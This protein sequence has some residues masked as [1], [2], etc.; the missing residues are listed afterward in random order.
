MYY[1]DSRKSGWFDR[2]QAWEAFEEQRI[3]QWTSLFWDSDNLYTRVN[4]EIFQ[5]NF[6]FDTS[7]KC[8]W[9]LP[10]YTSDR[11]PQSVQLQQ[12]ASCKDFKSLRAFFMLVVTADFETIQE[13]LSD[14]KTIL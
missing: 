5:V 7:R 8:F 2:L 1:V 6:I 13:S 3:L 10:S 4:L 12:T 14:L 9:L 11:Q